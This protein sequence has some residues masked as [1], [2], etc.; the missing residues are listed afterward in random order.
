VARLKEKPPATR[1]NDP[2][3]ATPFRTP[4]TPPTRMLCHGASTL[5]A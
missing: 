1:L 2:H 4:C 3:G 5:L